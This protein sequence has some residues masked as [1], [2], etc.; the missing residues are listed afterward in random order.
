MASS[1]IFF[2]YFNVRLLPYDFYILFHPLSFSQDSLPPYHLS[3]ACLSFLLYALVL[4][5]LLLCSLCSSHRS[6]RVPHVG[7]CVSHSLVP[8]CAVRGRFAF[9]ISIV[10]PNSRTSVPPICR[11]HFNHCATAVTIRLEVRL[12]TRSNM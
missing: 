12:K 6:F 8:V 10:S 9:V 7:L 1:G 5:P 11:Q 4:L 3:L 2:Y